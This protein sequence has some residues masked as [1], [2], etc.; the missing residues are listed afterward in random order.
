MAAS[1]CFLISTIIFIGLTSIQPFA[2]ALQVLDTRQATDTNGPPPGWSFV[3]CHTDSAGDRTL[4]AASFI[5]TTSMT[6]ALCIEF[7][8]DPNNFNPSNGFAGVEFEQECYCDGVIQLSAN[9][10]DP[11]DCNLPCK[12]DNTLT[13]GGSNRI[14]IFTNGTPSPKIPTAAL[15]RVSGFDGLLLPLWQYVGCYS[16]GPNRSLE[17]MAGTVDINLCPLICQN[18]FP[19]ATT[20]FS[21]SEFGHECWCGRSIASTA[22]RLPDIA[23]ESMGCF[24]FNDQACGGK[25]IMAIYE[26]LPLVLTPSQGCHLTTLSQSFKLEAVFIDSPSE[27][28]PITMTGIEHHRIPTGAFTFTTTTE[29]GILSFPTLTP[30]RR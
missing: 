10:T 3:G 11:G 12:G 1:I 14:S 29:A 7:C 30:A 22:Q 20:L 13:C 9:L 24:G 19:D 21:G 4:M 5:N 6:P 26:M 16:D 8:S 28:V 2:R 23:C 25:F 18:A 27:R 17:R 15:P